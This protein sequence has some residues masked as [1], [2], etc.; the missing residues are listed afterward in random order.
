MP[1]DLNRAS[2]DRREEQPPGMA[3]TASEA[4]WRH[5][6]GCRVVEGSP[7][8]GNTNRWAHKHQ[9][10]DD[11]SRRGT[12]ADNAIIES[13]NGSFRDECLSVNW[14]LSVEDACEKAANRRSEYNTFRLVTNQEA[15]TA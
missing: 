10:V 2:A 14:F 9:T 6:A 12:P 1:R 4:A 5:E 11:Y 8:S 3:A 15:A 7:V 13:F